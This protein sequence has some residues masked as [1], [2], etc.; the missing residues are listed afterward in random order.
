MQKLLPLLSWM[1]FPVYVWQGVQVRIKAPRLAPPKTGHAG[2]ISGKGKAIRL[3]VIGDSSAA[4]VGVND[5][6]EGIAANLSMAINQK[7]GQSVAWQSAGSNSATIAQIRDYSLPHI[8]SRDWSHIIIAA[9]TNDVKNF[10]TV[11]RFKRDFGTLLYAL[12]TRFPDAKTYWSPVI[13]MRDVPALPDALGAILEIRASA[14]NAMG[15]RLC[16]ERMA[17]A[18]PRLPIMDPSGFCADGFHA[19]A[20]GYKAWAEHIAK[21][22][23][24]DMTEEG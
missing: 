19:S 21:H 13:D 11:R 23:L 17:G 8:H 2:E 4:S 6:A 22:I 9:G 15:E 5:A 14:L 24:D 16:R 7:T 18:L 12:R 20:L 3:L 1:A 10:H